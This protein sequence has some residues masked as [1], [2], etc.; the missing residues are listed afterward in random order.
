MEVEGER[1]EQGSA[2]TSAASGQAPA[3]GAM[4]AEAWHESG[5]FVNAPFGL[6]PQ[7]LGAKQRLDPENKVV[8]HFKLLGRTVGKALQ[9]NR[10][11]DLPLNHVFYRGGTRDAAGTVRL[12]TL[13]ASLLRWRAPRAARAVDIQDIVRFDPALGQSMERLASALA[14]HRASKAA[15]SVMVDGAA[16]EDLCLTYTVPGYPEYS[17]C[18]DGA[19]VM[20]VGSNLGEYIAAV[21]DATLG[22]GVAHQLA[23]FREG[24]N[25]VF[26]LRSLECF[27]EDEIEAMLCGS[28]ESWTV[29][30]LSD[31][32][33]FDHGYTLASSP[34]K[35]FLEVLSELNGEDQKRFLRFVT[36]CPRLPMGGIAAL[37]PRLTVVRKHPSGV[38]SGAELL[39]SSNGTPVGSLSGAPMP[40]GNS[41]NN[42][43]SGTT[44]ADGDLPSVMTCANY[45]K[46]PPYSCKEI[47]AERLLYAIREGQGSFDLS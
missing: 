22:E 19:D 18:P 21:V 26:P 47:M 25:E 15:G 6:F 12:Q 34:V 41:S 16:I 36:G 23:A 3:A 31:G 40:S 28:G 32:I 2:S 4:H 38:A 35:C 44:A 46:L 27:F 39:G 9:D 11:L 45:I 8:E 43:N 10:L 1:Q 5:E 42:L 24:F 33:K 7:P 17:L 20:V 13:S 14:H 37:R 30:S 29:Q